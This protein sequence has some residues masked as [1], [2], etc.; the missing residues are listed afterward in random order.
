ART[1]AA[2]SARRLRRLSISSACSMRATG[3]RTPIAYSASADSWSSNASAIVDADSSSS[4][5]PEDAD[6]SLGVCLSC[7]LSGDP[8]S[9]N[10]AHGRRPPVRP[11]VRRGH[12]VRVQITGDLAKALAGVVLNDDAPDD[13]VRQHR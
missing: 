10:N 1:S 7:E 12:T 11:T 6:A 2:A 9:Q 4:A 5:R 13:V 8:A 3:P